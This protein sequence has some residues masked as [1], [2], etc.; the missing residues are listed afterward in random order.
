[1]LVKANADLDVLESL[2][3]LKESQTGIYRQFVYMKSI[4][5][6]IV[7]SKVEHWKYFNLLC[8]L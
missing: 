8:L 6:L 1:M 7:P 2:R 4:R 5:E 3:T